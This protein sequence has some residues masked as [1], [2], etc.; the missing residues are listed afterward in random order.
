MANVTKEWVGT[1]SFTTAD[2]TDYVFTARQA[3]T[4]ANASHRAELMLRGLFSEDGN[5]LTYTAPAKIVGDDGTEY[6]VDAAGETVVDDTNIAGVPA[7]EIQ[8]PA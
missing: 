5:D 4:I 8:D 1:Q 7:G 2:G 3:K 6:P